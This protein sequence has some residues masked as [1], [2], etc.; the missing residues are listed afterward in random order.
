MFCTCDKCNA[1]ICESLFFSY[2]VQFS[3]NPISIVIL[4]IFS[5]ILASQPLHHIRDLVRSCL[6][7]RI[8]ECDAAG[9][10]KSI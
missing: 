1:V 3:E 4:P 7:N 6:F 5:T 2:T 10:K 8:Y 9:F